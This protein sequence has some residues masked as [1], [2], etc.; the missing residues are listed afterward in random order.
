L[1]TK[2]GRQRG[3]DPEAAHIQEVLRR[4]WLRHPPLV[5]QAF[6]RQALA[7]LR[8]LDAACT[9]AD[10]LAAA[11]V[12]SLSNTRTP[13]SSPACQDSDHSPAPG[14]SPR[15]ATTDPASPTHGR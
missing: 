9:N 10:D 5:E 8:Q 14:C 3:I 4:D 11:A 13:R 2:A 12:E 1:L 7:L 15:S 6:G